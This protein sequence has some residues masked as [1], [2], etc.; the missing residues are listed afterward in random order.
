MNVR[1]SSPVLRRGH[2][3]KID[4]SHDAPYGHEGD[5]DQDQHVHRRHESQQAER[6]CHVWH[7]RSC[8]RIEIDPEDIG[9]GKTHRRQQPVDQPCGVP[10]RRSVEVRQAKSLTRRLGSGPNQPARAIVRRSSRLARSSTFSCC[11]KLNSAPRSRWERSAQGLPAKSN[12]SGSSNRSSP[13]SSPF[14][15]CPA[16]L[17]SPQVIDPREPS[18]HC[19]QCGMDLRHQPIHVQIGDSHRWFVATTPAH[20]PMARAFTRKAS[21]ARFLATTDGVS[22]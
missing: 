3:E 9:G 5:G 21:Q 4:G 2:H 19:F 15:S 1:S 8:R 12:C 14:R 11:T 20:R 18:V 17:N 16:D 13:S 6:R 7:A 10:T 22:A